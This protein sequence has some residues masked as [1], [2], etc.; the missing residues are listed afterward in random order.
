M[1]FNLPQ[2]D[3]KQSSGALPYSSLCDCKNR[4]RLLGDR[5]SAPRHA[6]SGQPCAAVQRRDVQDAAARQQAIIWHPASKLPLRPQE[7]AETAGRRALRTS[8]RS[9]WAARCTRLNRDPARLRA[10]DWLAPAPAPALLLLLLCPP[11]SVLLCPAPACCCPAG[12]QQ[13]V[14]SSRYDEVMR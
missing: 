1:V 6:G 5:Q 8:A 14:R 10:S 12:R 11:A 3:S 4:L 13:R 9:V 2:L 7:Q